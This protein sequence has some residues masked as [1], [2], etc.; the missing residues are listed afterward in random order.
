MRSK[1][2]DWLAAEL[3]NNLKSHRQWTSPQ[4]QN[5]LIQIMSK[6]VLDGIGSVINNICGGISV[7]VDETSDISKPEQVAICFRYVESSDGT[8]QETFVGFHD[9]PSTTG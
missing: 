7:I 6:Q 1:D 3:E 9:T 5:E 4:I 2:F 8:I